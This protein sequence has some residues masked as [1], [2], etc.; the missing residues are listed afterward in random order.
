MDWAY[1]QFKDE[2]ACRIATVKMLA[3]AEEK[4][5]DLSTKLTEANR[6]RKSVEVALAG[7]EKQVEDQH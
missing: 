4:I 7:A 6:K 2:E 3:M 1:A 5:K